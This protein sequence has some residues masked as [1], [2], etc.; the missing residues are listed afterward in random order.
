[1]IVG[2]RTLTVELK[3]ELR[4]VQVRLFSPEFDDPLWDC[5]YEIDWPEGQWKSHAQGNDSATAGT[6]HPSDSANREP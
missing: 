6:P 1:M 5:R 3:S 4:P 2:T